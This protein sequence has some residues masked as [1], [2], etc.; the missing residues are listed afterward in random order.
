M[1]LLIPFNIILNK[2]VFKFDRSY[3]DGRST[4][5]KLCNKDYNRENYIEEILMGES[6]NKLEKRRYKIFHKLIGIGK[7]KKPENLHDDIDNQFLD[8][9]QNLHIL[10]YDTSKD[11][12]PK[13][14]SLVDSNKLNDL[15]IDGFIILGYA[16]IIPVITSMESHNYNK[17]EMIEIFPKGYGIG[18]YFFNRLNME[19]EGL[20]I[21]D[22]LPDVLKWFFAKNNGFKIMMERFSDDPRFDCTNIALRNN[23]TCLS[24]LSD[25]LKCD[26]NAIDYVIRIDDHLRNNSDG[27]INEVEIYKPS[28]PKVIPLEYDID[29]NIEKENYRNTLKDLRREAPDFYK[30]AEYEIP[31]NDNLISYNVQ[32]FTLSIK[33]LKFNDIIVSHDLNPAATSSKLKEMATNW[34]R[35]TK[36]NVDWVDKIWGTS[37]PEICR[38]NMILALYKLNY[39][40]ADELNLLEQVSC[41]SYISNYSLHKLYN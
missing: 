24:F 7:K 36:E 38:K 19:I 27:D 35:N 9:T 11:R 39:V 22:P 17:L 4:I 32:E 14:K 13:L 37:V 41:A 10:L 25:E 18:S 28:I 16:I 26:Y 33:Y 6:N 23:A 29:I 2:M 20:W 5:F 8:N 12:H 31:D 21:V 40:K 15:I 34:Y 1:I 3:L 30:L